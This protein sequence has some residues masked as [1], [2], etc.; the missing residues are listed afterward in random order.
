L[1]VDYPADS[2]HFKYDKYDRPLRKAQM[3]NRARDVLSR[4]SAC[5]SERRTSSPLEK[6]AAP[7]PLAA[8][9]ADDSSLPAAA[10]AVDG[11]QWLAAE[12]ACSRPVAGAPGGSQPG[13]AEAD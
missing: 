11:S 9:S 5:R 2:E 8:G 13:E 3:P 7:R 10:V 12:V 4:R 6:S 1:P